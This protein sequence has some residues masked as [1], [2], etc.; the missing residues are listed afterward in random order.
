MTARRLPSQGG[1]EAI[2]FDLDGTLVDTAPDMVAVLIR[3]QEHH[4]QAALPYELA[5]NS[6]SN[7]AIGLLR[8]AFPHAGESE[9]KVLHA[10]YLENYSNALCEESDLFPPLREL[11]DTLNTCNRSWGIVTNKPKRMTDP[12]VEK[13]GIVGGAACVISGDTLAQRKPHP[14]PLLHAAEIT[15]VAPG[16]SIYVGDAER[17][18]EAGR[19]AGMTTIAVGYG[20]ITEDDDPH[21]WGAD[22]FAADTM[23]LGELLLKAVDVES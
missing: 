7:G 18:I 14:A 12:L 3:M 9:L 23:V 22:D 8:L 13:L 19:A 5:R 21:T 15:G 16:K 1:F 2:F 11:L 20:Y 6:V 10:E 4:Q 17:D